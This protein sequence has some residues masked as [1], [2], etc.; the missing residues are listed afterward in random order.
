MEQNML[1]SAPSVEDSKRFINLLSEAKGNDLAELWRT[2]SVGLGLD[3]EGCPCIYVL[4]V[5]TSKLASKTLSQSQILP[6]EYLMWEQDEYLKSNFSNTKLPHLTNIVTN[7]VKLPPLLLRCAHYIA[8]VGLNREG[9]FRIPG[10]P[11][12]FK[13]AKDRM[14]FNL[15]RNI[16]FEGE[17]VEDISTSTSTLEP[18]VSPSGIRYTTTPTST[19][20]SSSQEQELS[21]IIISD[22]FKAY[23]R[24]LPVPVFTFE[25]FDSI[26]SLVEQ[27]NDLPESTW[28]ESLHSILTSMPTAHYDL[29]QYL[30]RVQAGALNGPDM[31]K[32]LRPYRAEAE[33]YDMVTSST[34]TRP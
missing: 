9:L 5:L 11:Q 28:K 14:K 17:D 2:G 31:K 8:T 16:Q 15:G 4:P 12:L 29:L 18:Q 32:K 27:K 24:E 22:V 23:L 10:D 25:A 20:S 7:D 30:I 21:T 6:Q 1:S 33:G 19:S 34:S 3:N 26:I 13:L